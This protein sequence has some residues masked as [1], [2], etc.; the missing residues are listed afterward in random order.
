LVWLKASFWLL[1]QH[2][3]LSFTALLQVFIFYG[4]DVLL[5]L[6]LQQWLLLVV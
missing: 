2:K 5:D 4:N 6:A 1:R 3:Y